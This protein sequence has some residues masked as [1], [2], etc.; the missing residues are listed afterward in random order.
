[1]QDTQSATAHQMLDEML[2]DLQDDINVNDLSLAEGE[3]PSDEPSTSSA[4]SQGQQAPEI[5]DPDVAAV[6]AGE[7]QSA[8]L[9]AMQQQI[10]QL[11]AQLAAKNDVQLGP[12]EYISESE[13]E[14]LL[15]DRAKLNEKLNA[16]AQTAARAAMAQAGQVMQQQFSVQQMVNDF[17][18]TNSDLNAH[19]DT[20][21]AVAEKVAR[22]NPA[23]NYAQI[24]DK[25][26]KATRILKK[27]PNP[28]TT[29]KSSTKGQAA[30]SLPRA[31][32]RA[33]SPVN[34]GKMDAHEA[35]IDAMLKAVR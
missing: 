9:Y 7:D 25:A 27:L 19:R 1:M 13:F 22:Q 8:Q 28:I 23:L 12:V 2:V 21:R 16:V 15:G 11:Q 29:G 34:Q 18:A 35:A 24:M 31:G 4:P 5:D 10:A 20:V 33:G 17:Y 6:V 3:E 30:P 26:A 32:A 14:D